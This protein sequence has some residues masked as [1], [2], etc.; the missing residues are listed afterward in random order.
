MQQSFGLSMPF[1]PVQE[2]RSLTYELQFLHAALVARD[3]RTKKGLGV[4]LV[5]IRFSQTAPTWT[6]SAL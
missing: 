5:R 3:G 2:Q 6:V 4:L 1:N